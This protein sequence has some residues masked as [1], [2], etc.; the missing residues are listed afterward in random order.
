[1]RTLYDLYREY[2]LD[3]DPILW[4]MGQVNGVHVDN[5]ARLGLLSEMNGIVKQKIEE[6]QPFVP[7]DL[8]P[9]KRFKRPPET[10]REV[11]L[12]EVP[13]AEVKTCS[14][15]G[16]QHITKGEHTAR[17][18][19]KGDVPLNLC[20]KAAIELRPGVDTEYDVV[21]PFNP[22]SDEQLKAY[23]EKFKHRLGRNWKTG[24]ATLDAK[25]LQKFIDKY[26]EQHPIYAH[27]HA[28]RK[29]RKAR[30]YAK[31][32]VADEDGL[33]YGQFKHVPE[34]FRLSQAEHNFMN[35]SHR[36]NAPY[37][38]EL[39]RLLV[40][41]AG[42]SFVEA[43]SSS[44]E[45][46]FS[47]KLMGSASY[48]AMAKGGVHAAWALSKLG[49]EVTPLNIKRAKSPDDYAE[50]WEAMGKDPEAIQILYETKKRTVHGVSYGMGAKLLHESYPEFFPVIMAP[51]PRTGR[52][53]RCPLCSAQAE[54]DDFYSFVPDLQAWH[55]DTQDRAF[56]Q[57]YLQS[58]WGF[59]NYYYSVYS[60]DSKLGKYKMG[61]DA[62]AVIAFQPQHANAMFQR[63]NLKL[64]HSTIRK[65]GKQNK[66]FMTA[67]GHV[68]DSNGLRVPDDDIMK[69]ATMMAEI[70][71]R[72]IKQFEG[73]QIGVAVK[74][75]KNWQ[76]VKGVLTV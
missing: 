9:L 65:M 57:G 60:W 49:L 21:L 61:P 50:F 5:D 73:L 76:D 20:Y 70:M 56:K 58:P 7:S 6:A 68:H 37:A 32:W 40:T 64:I 69:A 34:T 41:P 15:C 14:L 62:K 53:K 63:E 72:P 22:G 29:V 35:V 17:K 24:E 30:G 3:L 23:A 43:D 54:I 16:A 26:G 8:Y 47:G 42:Y 2:V 55:K 4:E 19:G 71:N 48:M 59:R 74:A 18:G 45:A 51:D 13:N 33:I 38:K 11:R 25:E 75:G 52:M 28:I 39:R 46:V 1:M 36:G 67:I 12:I 44:I 10:K 27:A 66:W 31:A